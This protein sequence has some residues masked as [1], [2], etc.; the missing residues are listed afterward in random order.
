METCKLEV[1]LIKSAFFLISIL[2]FIAIFS[3]PSTHTI[4]HLHKQNFL[5]FLTIIFSTNQ[6]YLSISIFLSPVL[7]DF[8][9]LQ[10]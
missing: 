5:F 1:Q 10:V 3:S 2:N 4:V 7:T 9:P 6:N 8:L